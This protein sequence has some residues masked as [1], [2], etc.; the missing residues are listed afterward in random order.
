[1]S[2]TTQ[3]RP[4]GPFFDH[5]LAIRQ[6]AEG[7]RE[8]LRR[9]YDREAPAMLGVATRILRRRELAEEAVQDAF[10]QV[11]RRAD[12]FDP[13][14]GAG[15]AWLFSIVRNRALNILRDG[16]REIPTDAD[17][18]HDQADER[19]DPEAAVLLLDETSRLRVC[20]DELEPNRR[21]GIVL[22]Y[23]YGLSH[24]EVAATLGVPLGTAKS[25]LRR[26]FLQV[27]ECMQ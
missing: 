3:R 9:L 25:W 10:V 21:R 26:A 12:T 6:C 2:E 15:R 5:S 8:A 18:L 11:W 14:R 24:G 19:P 17:L 7:S 27:Q 4:P 20:L 16:A 1:M 13:A 23:T 22:A